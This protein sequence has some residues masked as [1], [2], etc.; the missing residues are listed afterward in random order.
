MGHGLSHRRIAASCGIGRPT[1]SEY[2]RRAE[3]VGLSWPLPI[4]LDDARLERQLFPPPPDLPAQARGIPD[5]N[6]IHKELRHKGVTLFLL[7]QEYRQH[8][9]DGYQYSWLCEHYRVWQGKLDV[10]MRQYH[11]AGEKLIRTVLGSRK[12]PQQAYRSC[13]GILRLCAGPQSL[14]RRLHRPVHP[15]D[16]TV[17]RADDC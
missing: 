6:C 5:W 17:A 4:D 2:L 11:R 9:P 10:V 14:P 12:H 3:E 16:P 7:W 13:L 1:V 15:A 8:H